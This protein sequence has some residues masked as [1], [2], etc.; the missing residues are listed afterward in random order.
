MAVLEVMDATGAKQAEASKALTKAGG[1]VAEAASLVI[2]WAED[3]LRRASGKRPS[4]AGVSTVREGGA[5]PA[6]YGTW[7]PGLTAQVS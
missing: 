7:P 5:L 3:R 1:S 4:A 2:K 6:G